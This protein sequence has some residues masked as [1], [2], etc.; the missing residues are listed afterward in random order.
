MNDDDFIRKIN[1][2]ENITILDLKKDT[3]ASDGNTGIVKNIYT[4][5]ETK[6]N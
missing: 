6:K 5:D 2:G 4:K 1:K 3:S